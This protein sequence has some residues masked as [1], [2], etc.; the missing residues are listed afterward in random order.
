MGASAVVARPLK[1]RL[2]LK[3]V[4][5]LSR[6]CNRISNGVVCSLKNGYLHPS[7]CSCTPP[8]LTHPGRR[9]VRDSG[10]LL[11]GRAATGGNVPHANQTPWRF[12]RSGHTPGRGPSDRLR[13]KLKVNQ[14]RPTPSHTLRRSKPRGSRGLS[15]RKAVGA[16]IIERMEYRAYE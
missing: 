14:R 16:E 7:T 11:G 1:F 3:L 12:I 2:S 8:T 6:S 10:G 15:C 13:V 9:L 5:Y 4:P